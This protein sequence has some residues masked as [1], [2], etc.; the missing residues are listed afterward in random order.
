[1]K[2]KKNSKILMGI[3]AGVIVCAVIGVI[4]LTGGGAANT[5]SNGPDLRDPTAEVNVPSP[6]VPLPS[7]PDFDL[8]DPG[9]SNG[10]M[11]T[12]DFILDV[13]GN[14]GNGDENNTPIQPGATPLEPIP[15]PSDPPIT[16][17]S[18]TPTPADDDD[19]VQTPAKPIEPALPEQP[20]DGGVII[21]GDDHDHAPYSCN[22]KNHKCDSAITHA[23]VTNL[24]IEGCTYCGSHSCPSFYGTDQWGNGGLYPKLCPKY[25]I[26]SDPVHTCQDC[27]KKTGDGSNGTC[28]QFVNADNCPNCGKHVPSWT[29]H[30]C[31]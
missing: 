24:E 17:P 19:T 6:D 5:E 7:T 4:I 12:P 14:P 29:C 11:P 26:K 21:G 1:M 25:N 10:Q 9:H 18:P 28:A 3:I 31:G 8:A 15:R 16:F 30:T 20:S 22:T 13:G 23:F 27:G 2:R